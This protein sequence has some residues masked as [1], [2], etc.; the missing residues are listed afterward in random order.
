MHWSGD[1]AVYVG[2][3]LLLVLLYM[4]FILLKVNGF[5][6]GGD[7]LTSADPGWQQ[8]QTAEPADYVTVDD[9]RPDE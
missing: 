1:T 3:L 5:L 8:Q 6:P 9:F 2:F 7:R 4:G